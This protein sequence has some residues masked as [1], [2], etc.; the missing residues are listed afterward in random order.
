MTGWFQGFLSFCRNES[1]WVFLKTCAWMGLVLLIAAG[2]VSYG[3]LLFVKAD[4]QR[5]LDNATRAAIMQVDMD[6]LKVG[7]VE[8]FED[9]VEAVFDQKMR[10]QGYNIQSKLLTLNS[11]NTSLHSEVD[12]IINFHPFFFGPARNL[13]LSRTSTVQLFWA[14]D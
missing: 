9:Q 5:D 7:K 4:A 3:P 14:D 12:I 2:V 6:K 8:W 1:G 13:I 11:E 10:E